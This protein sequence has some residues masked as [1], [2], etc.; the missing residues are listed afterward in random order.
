MDKPTAYRG[1]DPYVFVCYS[2]KDAE[3][4]LAEIAWMAAHEVNLWY[5]EGITPGVEWSEALADAIQGC[6]KFLF[7][8]SPASVSSEHCRRELNFAQEEGCDVL[9][10]YLAPTELPPGLRLSL[11][12]RQAIAR[13]ELSFDNFRQTLLGA[14]G[15]I[16]LGQ[17]NVVRGVVPQRHPRLT[18]IAGVVLLLLAGA[19]W[20]FGS[21]ADLGENHDAKRDFGPDTH[22][23]A[24]VLQNSVAVLPF[25]NLSPEPNDDYFA[26]GIH[27]EILTQIGKVDGLSVIARTTMLGYANT[28]KSVAEIADELN[29]QT[30]MAGGVRYSDGQV[31]LN[32][33]LI[34]AESGTQL[35]SDAFQEPL[36]DVFNIQVAIARRIAR[37]LKLR[38][39]AGDRAPESEPPTKNPLAYA[40]YLRANSLVSPLAPIGPV[41]SELDRAID[42]DPKFASAYASKAF[43]Q[44][45]L[46]PWPDFEPD[47]VRINELKEEARRNARRALEIDPDEARALLALGVLGIGSGRFE[48]ARVLLERA[49]ELSPNDIYSI[50]FLVVVRMMQGRWSDVL[51]LEMKKIA[52]DPQNYFHWFS[53]SINAWWFEEY[54]VA[55]DAA[56]NA[57]SMMPSAVHGY[58]A[59]AMAAAGS[60]E[61][62][63]A[64]RN[65]EHAIGIG[66]ETSARDITVAMAASVYNQLGLTRQASNMLEELNTIATQQFVAPSERLLAYVGSDDAE[67]I[68]RWLSEALE[69]ELCS[70]ACWSILHLPGHQALRGVREHPTVR[71][72]VE[73]V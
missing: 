18:I 13:F 69:D 68:A 38:V 17:A 51:T 52:L 44:A 2:H 28:E 14:L 61:E 41:Y 63:I 45:L 33:E 37:T 29:V 8:V 1:S 10:V 25:S 53:L 39:S 6:S 15:G 27:E 12:N 32:V 30:I 9:V 71:A 56:Q 4:V 35:W 19:V 47:R 73:G 42:A 62:S 60:R 36:Q 23:A 20:W 58:L 48:E 31:R 24:E 7:F 34:D 64:V 67:M 50:N 46:V 65:V 40:H 49:Y 55:A 59:L 3:A 57:I 72:F 21:G 11:N 66:R 54:A 26:S 70:A 5:D 16:Q 22:P 43:Y